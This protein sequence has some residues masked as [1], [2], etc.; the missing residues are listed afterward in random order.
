MATLAT[1]LHRESTGAVDFYPALNEVVLGWLV[2]QRCGSEF[3]DTRALGLTEQCR[4]SAG[5]PLP[6]L[7]VPAYAGRRRPRRGAD[8]PG[9]A[10]QG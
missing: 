2:A 5:P 10:R 3:D 6:G 9:V 7:L 4:R 8:Q 1:E